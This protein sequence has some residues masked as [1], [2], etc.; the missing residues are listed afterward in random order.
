[1]YLRVCMEANI[2]SSWRYFLAITKLILT[3]I[4]TGIPPPAPPA[5]TLGSNTLLLLQHRSLF[6]NHRS[7]QKYFPFFFYTF[8]RTT[9]RPTQVWL[10]LFSRPSLPL[11]WGGFLETDRASERTNE[12]TSQPEKTNLLD[13]AMNVCVCVCV[14]M[15]AYVWEENLLLAPTKRTTC[16]FAPWLPLRKRT[17]QRGTRSNPSFA[18]GPGPVLV[19]SG[20]PSIL[21]A[22]ELR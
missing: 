20:P 2:F 16:S 5:V 10:S 9:D 11:N 15:C 1:M 8:R 21:I 3:P 7:W 13:S 4:L 22:K 18:P 12:R 19:R 6:W 17:Q 14:C